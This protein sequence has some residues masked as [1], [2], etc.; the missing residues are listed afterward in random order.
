MAFLPDSGAVAVE[1]E[2]PALQL[3]GT[4]HKGTISG[5]EV[6]YGYDT[7]SGSAAGRR[8]ATTRAWRSGARTRWQDVATTQNGGGAAPAPRGGFGTCVALARSPS[9]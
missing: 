4:P 7:D 9:E 5:G 1:Q 8:A 6:R 2:S 3:I